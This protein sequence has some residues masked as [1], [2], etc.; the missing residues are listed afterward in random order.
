MRFLLISDTHGRHTIDARDARAEAW[1]VAA[2]NEHYR[3][4]H[5]M[6]WYGPNTRL[7]Y[8]R[9]E[10]ATPAGETVIGL[11]PGGDGGHSRQV[12][13]MDQ[14]GEARHGPKMTAQSR[15]KRPIDL[16]F[17]KTRQGD[18][19]RHTTPPRQVVASGAFRYCR[20]HA[21]VVRGGAKALF[22]RTFQRFDL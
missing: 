14:A 7:D 12:A 4:D 15:G 2:P 18:S 16:L 1:P 17:P 22:S 3:Q 11:G 10:T 9:I 8:E 5:M 13:G 20:S 19:R 6:C 21:A